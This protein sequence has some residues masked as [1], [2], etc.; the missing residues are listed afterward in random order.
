M[1]TERERFKAWYGPARFPEIN[2]EKVAWAAWQ[3]ALAQPAPQYASP[4]DYARQNPL[5]G[6]A[7]V[8]EVIAERLRAGENYDAVLWDYGLQRAQPAQ[9]VA[10]LRRWGANELGFSDETEAGSFPVYAA[11][12]PA[13]AVW[14]QG[15]IDALHK[16]ADEIGS[17]ARTPRLAD[18]PPGRSAVTDFGGYTRCTRHDRRNCAECA[19]PA[20]APAA[21]RSTDGAGAREGNERGHC[22]EGAPVRLPD[23]GSAAG[24]EA[25]SARNPAPST[26]STDGGHRGLSDALRK[27]SGEKLSSWDRRS[28]S[29]DA[30]LV[31]N[32]L[33]ALLPHGGD[34]GAFGKAVS[35]LHA[36]AQREIDALR[37][38]HATVA[39]DAARRVSELRDCLSA[40]VLE[41]DAG[42]ITLA[43]MRE[44]R[45]V[46]DSA[47]KGER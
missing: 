6:V 29:P 8:F 31:A 38:G 34:N 42:G 28:M 12:Q 32:R 18:A 16:D 19:H 10:W 41:H 44:A 33:V 35:E 1:T 22:A 46:I 15:Q 9:P 3:A 23:K 5:G 45:A 30:R 36:E 17:K 21:E 39:E 11:P 37:A 27:G 13:P 20:T 43:T 40:M 7:R 4:E 47:R 2:Y 25:A 24:S 26:P 14:T